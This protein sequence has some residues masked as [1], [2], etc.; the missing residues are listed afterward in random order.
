[1]D[2]APKTYLYTVSGL[3][4]PKLKMKFQM[5]S[6]DE[7]PNISSIDVSRLSGKLISLIKMMGYTLNLMAWFCLLVGLVVLF[8]IINHQINARLW[9]LNLL[10][11]LGAQ[12]S[13]CGAAA[14]SGLV[15]VSSR[16]C[17]TGTLPAAP[18][19]PAA[20]SQP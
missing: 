19:K 20:T 13:S 8:S 10:K 4:E 2:D 14:S 11:P 7:F 18:R 5:N 6:A 3:D 15:R 17:K 12:L 1:M 9:D 16:P